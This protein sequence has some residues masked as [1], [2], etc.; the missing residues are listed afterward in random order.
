MPGT[1]GTAGGGAAAAA[2]TAS[3]RSASSAAAGGAA[4]AAEAT[5]PPTMTLAPRSGNPTRQTRATCTRRMPAPT[6]R[7]S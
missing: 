1:A 2:A 3:G 5:S 4:A 7:L 6:L